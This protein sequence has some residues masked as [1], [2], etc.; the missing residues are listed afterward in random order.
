MC[1][2]GWALKSGV[3]AKSLLREMV[4][5]AGAQRPFLKEK[6]NPSNLLSIPQTGGKSSK[7]LGGNIGCK[8]KTSSWHLIGFPPW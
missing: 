6:L 3:D 4:L 1:R 8:D 5:R 7:R 2:M